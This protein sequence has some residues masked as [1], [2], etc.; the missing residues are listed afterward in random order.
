MLVVFV[1][2]VV[3]LVIVGYLLD[4]VFVDIVC[5]NLCEWLKNYVIVYVVGI[6]FICDCLLYICEQLLDFC[7]DVFGSGLYLQ[8]VMFDGKGNFMLVEGL[9]LFIVGG[10]LF[11]LC[12]EVFE[13]LLLMI[14]I[15][16]SEGL[17]YCYGMGLVWDVDV[18]LVIEFLYII[19]VMED[20][21][22]FGVQLCVFCGCVW[23]YLGGVG[24]IL[25]LLQMVIL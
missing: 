18:D 22:V 12:Q 25:L 2:L 5:V 16:G 1:G 13:G 21:C 23:F 4:V 14:Q 19:Y 9:M 7:F 20:L 6:D 15:D 17:V 11:V 10:G 3:F 8:V 24:L